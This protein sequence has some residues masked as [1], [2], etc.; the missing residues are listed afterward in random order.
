[1]EEKE[2]V[3]DQHSAFHQSIFY[4]EIVADQHSAFHQSIFYQYNDRFNYLGQRE[5]NIVV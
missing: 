5:S 3:G 1:M 4:Q 2:H